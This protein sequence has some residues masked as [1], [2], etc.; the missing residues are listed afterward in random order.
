[1]N[2]IKMA[3]VR[4]ILGYA[5]GLLGGWVIAKGYI[6]PEAWAAVQDNLSTVI[7]SAVG[8][9]G[10]IALSLMEKKGRQ[11][12]EPS[13]ELGLPSVELGLPSVELGLVEYPIQAQTPQTPEY[14]TREVLKA[15]GWSK[16]N[17][18][19][20]LP[21]LQA[22][23]RR[24]QIDTPLR[25]AHFIAQVSHESSCGVF[26]RELWNGKG[27]QAKYDT[28]TDLGNTP[29]ADGD[30]YHNRGVGLIQTTGET[31]IE[32]ALAELGYPPDSN[33]SL[34]MPEGA[35]LSAC[36]FWYKH[37]L[38]EIAERS[39]AKVDRCT[40][41]VNGGYNGLAERQ[42]YFDRVMTHYAE[43]YLK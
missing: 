3:V 14:L 19:K 9:G 4:H 31:N 7:L 15:A 21:H 43:L 22:G 37:G 11:G 25:V 35:S 36:F 34:A 29:A 39:G 10:A 12:T 6:T 16:A 2:P 32:E 13:V 8:G 40:R 26:T 30:G 20:F 18:A 41:V 42:R 23:A 1:M 27:A 33:D 17:I 24:Y 28:R 38:N 5:G